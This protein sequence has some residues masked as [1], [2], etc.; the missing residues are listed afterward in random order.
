MRAGR[1][2]HARTLMLV[3]LQASTHW[4]VMTTWM[5]LLV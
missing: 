3:A 1:L 2:E 4:S 5:G